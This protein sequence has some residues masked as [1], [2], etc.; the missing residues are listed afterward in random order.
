[1]E[2]HAITAIINKSKLIIHKIL[3]TKMFKKP[4]H[5]QRSHLKFCRD[6]SD[7]MAVSS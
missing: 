6:I 3:F 1:M 7:E 5:R 2:Y 4:H